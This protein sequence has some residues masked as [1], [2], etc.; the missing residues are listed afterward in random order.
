LRK[1]VV[2]AFVTLDGVAENVAGF[3]TEWD[4]YDVDAAGAAL[5]S[6]Q[7]AVILGRRTYDEWA[8]FWPDSQIEPFASFINTVPKYIA[9]S[10]PLDPEWAGASA[11]DAEPA[12]FVRD[13]KNQPGGDIGVH[14][15]ISVAQTLLIAG[16]V[17]DLR[18]VIAP[19]IAGVGRRLLHGLPTIPLT[20]IRSVTS[21][22]GFM[23]LDC[24]IA[25]HAT[26]T[27]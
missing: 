13:L 23:I 11:I 12:E 26:L 9:T 18:L 8:P 4:D 6:T 20:P 14:G 15:S 21:T 17:D 25:A 27:T 2:S 3:F 16:L 24:R 1:V 10:R 22:T 19:T 7:D 5:I